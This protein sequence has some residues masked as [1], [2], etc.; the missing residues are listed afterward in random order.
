M[1]GFTFIC[2]NYGSVRALDSMLSRMKCF[3][4]GMSQNRVQAGHSGPRDRPASISVWYLPGNIPQRLRQVKGEGRHNLFGPR[5]GGRDML[6]VSDM[7][8]LG[9]ASGKLY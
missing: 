8:G 1:G 4:L 3:L 5:F 7:I 9:L 6:R 2:V